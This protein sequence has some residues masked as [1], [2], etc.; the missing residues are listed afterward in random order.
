M[1]AQ[2]WHFGFSHF[3][4]YV[5]VT[6]CGNFDFMRMFL[7]FGVCLYGQMGVTSNGCLDVVNFLNSLIRFIN[8]YDGRVVSVNNRQTPN[9]FVFLV[10]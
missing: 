6:V 1:M 4:L 7:S 5:D 2:I 9:R 8:T 3:L 10:F